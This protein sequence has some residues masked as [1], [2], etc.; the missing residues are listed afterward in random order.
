MINLPP[1]YK[2]LYNSDTLFSVTTGTVK[3]LGLR[4]MEST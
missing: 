3:E 2:T 1:S 4:A